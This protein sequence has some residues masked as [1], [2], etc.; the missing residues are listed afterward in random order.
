MDIN[1]N[2]FFTCMDIRLGGRGSIDLISS[3]VIKGYLSIIILF[4]V[5]IEY[6]SILYTEFNFMHY[7][8]EY[9]CWVIIR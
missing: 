6:H 2:F 5:A 1:Y 7:A 3:V 9:C 8:Y 4:K